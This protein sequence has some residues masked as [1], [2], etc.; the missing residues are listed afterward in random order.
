MG[1]TLPKCCWRSK[2]PCCESDPRARELSAASGDCG[3]L[4]KLRALASLN[5]TQVGFCCCFGFFYGISL[6][7]HNKFL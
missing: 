3:G 5:R 1:D 7:F 2:P 6:G 4:Y